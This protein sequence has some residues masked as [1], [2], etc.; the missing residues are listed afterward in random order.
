VRP[1]FLPQRSCN[2]WATTSGRTITEKPGPKPY[3]GP[4]IRL[5]Q[6]EV[7][8]SGRPLEFVVAVAVVILL[9]VIVIVLVILLFLLLLTV[10]RNRCKESTLKPPS[11]HIFKL[12]KNIR[13]L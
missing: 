11:L 1:P 7:Q 6:T 10:A 8:I 5:G 12:I 4:E 3:S 2:H 9:R 13:L